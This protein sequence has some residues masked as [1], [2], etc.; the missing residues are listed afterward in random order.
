MSHDGRRP[1]LRLYFF[2]RF[3]VQDAGNEPLAF[4]GKKGL[5]IIAYLTRCPGMTATRERLADLLWSDSDGEHS[6]NSLRQTL[7]V[8]RHDLSSVGA[9]ILH[10]NKDAIGV[11]AGSIDSDVAILESVPSAH[12]VSQLEKAIS[13]YAGPFLDGF[14][15]GSGAFDDWVAAEREKFAV[16]LYRFVAVFADGADKPL[17]KNAVQRGD[18]V[19]GLH[20]HV[21][22]SSDHVD[23]V[24][25]VD[26]GKHKVSG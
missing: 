21:Q 20:A 26:G 13:V 5:A 15:A 7:S 2:G 10:S 19:V 9:N 22:E 12:S 16:M 24:V 8:L 6:R 17:R 14:F 18:E 4:T 11:D 25:G 1:K 3:R 23:Y